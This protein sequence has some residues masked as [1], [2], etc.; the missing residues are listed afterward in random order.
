MSN[1]FKA[2]RAELESEELTIKITEIE[3]ENL[4]D[5]DTTVEVHYSSLNYKDGMAV[6]GNKARIM[7][8]LPM[9]PGIDLAGIVSS[10]SNNNFKKGDEVIVTGW[11]LG[12]THSGGYSQIVRVNSDWLIKKPNNISLKH[13][14]SV[15]TAGLTA[16]LSVIE[17]EKSGITNSSGEIV[18]TGA[19]GGVGSLSIMLLN[20]LGYSITAVTGRMELEG[21]LKNLGANNIMSR[22]DLLAMSRPLNSGKWA[23]AIDTVGS[24]LLANVLSAIDYGG[25]VACC[26]NASG[27]DLPTTV[28]PFILRK[29]QLI[30]IDSV[31][32]PTNLRKDAW[33]RLGELITPEEF[34]SITNEVSLS[35]IEKPAKL[36]LEGKIQGRTV[37]NIKDI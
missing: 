15:G 37:V 10:T 4:P 26:G 35:E 34:Q 9:S 16:M 11:G 31:Y 17:L 20:K 13:S 21:Y 12:E 14:M 32:C 27:N 28:L 30:G 7:R 24:T 19:A 22:D 25:S 33:K 6:N 23:G 18:V 1:T 29:I 5:G 36:I 8:N 3:L 2:L